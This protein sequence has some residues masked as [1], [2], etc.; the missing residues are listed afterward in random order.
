[1]K[2]KEFYKKM[3]NAFATANDDE[4]LFDEINFLLSELENRFAAGYI[5]KHVENFGTVE[6]YK[7]LLTETE[8]FGVW[9]EK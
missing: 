8:E 6:E 5:T 3:K 9:D 4:A 7:D 1:M 2:K